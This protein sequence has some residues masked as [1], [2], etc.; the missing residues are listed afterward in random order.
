MTVM[1]YFS[2]FSRSFLGRNCTGTAVLSYI[3]FY[4]VTQ[5]CWRGLGSPNSVCLSVCPSV[6]RVLCD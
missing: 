5:L 6:T 1:A 4:R 2:P 3:G